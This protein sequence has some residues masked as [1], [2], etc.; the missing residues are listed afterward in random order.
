MIF[1]IRQLL[2]GKFK[3][4][5]IQKY[6][7]L[8]KNPKL[9][10]AETLKEMED[11]VKNFPM[12]ENFRILLALNLL[13]LNDYR[14]DNALTKAAVYSSDRKRLKEWVDLIIISLAKEEN[15]IESQIAEQ[16]TYTVS[17]EKT[18]EVSVNEAPN[19]EPEEVTTENASIAKEVE[20]DV[21]EEQIIESP[22]KEASNPLENNEDELAD[23][24]EE[25]KKIRS[26]KELL[27]LVRKR[28]DEIEAE[29][30]Q[31][32]TEDS[33]D[34]KS[35]NAKLIDRFIE[36]EP[37]ISRPDKNEFFDPQNEA[38]ES[39]ID[40]DDFFV[41]ETLAQIH[42]QQSNLKKAEEIYRKLILKYPEKSSY[43]AAQIEKLTKK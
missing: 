13:I 42:T 32:E 39:S 35:M 36:Q 37:S 20:Q 11:L 6:H 21:L 1:L 17:E 18:E 7:Q 26:K 25:K 22:Q 15:E 14:F 34:D 12:V 9:L 40:E 43:F 27:K 19:E 30:A 29:K 28:L 5:N 3:T 16:K 2:I 8:I 4:L 38:I 41:T 24:E 33:G 10:N 23:L 31:K